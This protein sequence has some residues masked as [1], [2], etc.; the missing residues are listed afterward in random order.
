M[1]MM[2]LDDDTI[3]FHPNRDKII[4]DYTQ[5]SLNANYRLEETFTYIRDARV[6]SLGEAVMDEDKPHMNDRL[7]KN[8]FGRLITSGLN[9]PMNVIYGGNYIDI[10]DTLRITLRTKG[11]VKIKEYY[12][13]WKD[14]APGLHTR[15]WYGYHTLPRE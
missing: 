3:Y 4:T 5:M 7:E 9:T 6:E 15:I 13:R 14:G 8:Y 11:P 10:V 1:A 2:K 12:G